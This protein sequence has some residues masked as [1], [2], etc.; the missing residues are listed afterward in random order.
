[1]CYWSL[2]KFSLEYDIIVLF[3]LSLDDLS[4]GNRIAKENNLDRNWGIA[5]GG[6]MVWI[7]NIAR[8][9]QGAFPM[10]NVQVGRHDTYQEV[11]WRKNIFTGE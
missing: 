8:A 3:P 5:W 11:K 1:M 10:P 2:H 7:N 9:F 4:D 6:L